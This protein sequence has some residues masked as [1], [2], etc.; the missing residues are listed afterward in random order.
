MKSMPKLWR[1]GS[2][3][4]TQYFGT[5][6]SYSHGTSLLPTSPSFGVRRICMGGDFIKLEEGQGLEG[7]SK[8]KRQDRTAKAPP[9]LQV[10]SGNAQHMHMG[11]E[12]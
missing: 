2:D 10:L 5:A 3:R 12:G 11:T 1:L 6:V 9:G 8:L 7:D 4:R